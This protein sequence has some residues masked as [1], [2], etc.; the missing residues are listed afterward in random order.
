M[1]ISKEEAESISWIEVNPYSNDNQ[2]LISYKNFVKTLDSN[3]VKLVD[4]KIFAKEIPVESYKYH[5]I[6]IVSK[7]KYIFN[8][9]EVPII[10][11]I[12]QNNYYDKIKTTA[13]L[14]LISRKSALESSMIELDSL[15]SLYKK[16]L[17]AESEKEATGTN[18]FL[19][20]NVNHSKEVDIFDKYMLMNE[21]LIEVNKQLTAENEV[22]NV[23]SSFN[24]IGMKVKTW[25]KN[26]AALGFLGGFVI[27][28]L[29][30]SFSRMDKLLLNFDK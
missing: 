13:Y 30:I 21:Q 18:I 9:L 6:K 14:N 22:V 27:M 28:F 19:S 5:V 2:E 20:E 29:F 11:S 7:D 25:Y 1:N 3:T 4:Y 16:V 8:K 15:R 10:N 12:V 26:F 24:S 23:V 17:L